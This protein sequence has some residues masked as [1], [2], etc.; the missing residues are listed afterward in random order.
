[1]ASSI[2]KT[3]TTLNSSMSSLSF[4]PSATP[5]FS[6]IIQPCVPGGV[7]A[8]VNMTESYCG[9]PLERGNYDNVSVAMRACCNGADFII[10]QSGCNIYCKAEGQTT[11]ELSRCLVSNLNREDGNWQG[12]LCNSNAAF[13]LQGG[14]LITLMVAGLIG[15]SFFAEFPV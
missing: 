8:L 4:T 6:P 10:P 15:I 14:S 13:R 3:T 11:K 9:V 5:S 2:T 12:T 1:M 7:P